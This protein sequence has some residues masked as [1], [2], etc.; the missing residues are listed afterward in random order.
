MPDQI[1]D[2]GAADQAAKDAA[3]TAAAAAAGAS[4]QSQSKPARPEGLG[5]SYW[6]DET[7]VDFGKLLG[8]HQS[9]TEFKAETEKRLGAVPENLA[10]YKPELPKDFK[11]PEGMKFEAMPEDAPVLKAAREWAKAAGLSPEQFK[12]LVGLQ[13][14]LAIA[15]AQELQAAADMEK[16]KLGEKGPGRLDHVVTFLQTKLGNEAAN[17]IIP[18]IFTAKQLAAYE[19]LIDLAKG[20]SPKF[21]GNGRDLEGGPEEISD[22]E[23]DRMS[24]TAKIDYAR[25]RTAAK[26]ANKG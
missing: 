5:D 2:Q 15:D 21:N 23:Y 3:A 24:P 13:T 7:G 16:A 6:N 25:E 9:L 8:E 19:R 12:G 4:D 26:Q 1:K 14:Q 17:E 11:L 10:D 22:E 20:G 18:M